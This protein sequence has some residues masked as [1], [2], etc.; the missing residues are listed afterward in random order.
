MPKT[1]LA[2]YQMICPLC[3]SNGQFVTNDYDKAELFNTFFHSVFTINNSVASKFEQHTD[4]NMDMQIFT[5]NEVRAT[6][7][8]YKKFSSCG[9]DGC[10]AKFLKL[11]PELCIP[12]TD[13]FNT[14]LS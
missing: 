1:A 4:I 7:L 2:L 9:P 3:D 11:F 12:L 13:I 8:A 10:P 5:S 6:I 14:S